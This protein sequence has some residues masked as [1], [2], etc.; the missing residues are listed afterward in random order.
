[1]GAGNPYKCSI[2]AIIL[3]ALSNI[4]K[5]LSASFSL[6]LNIDFHIPA[7]KVV[8]AG[9]F[10][11]QSYWSDLLVS[12]NSEVYLQQWTSEGREGKIVRVLN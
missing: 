8:K 4:I 5:V 9:Q 12:S 7:R 6:I 11:F 10:D 3:I 1:M 2:I